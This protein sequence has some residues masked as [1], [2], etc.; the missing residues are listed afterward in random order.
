M[1]RT[2]ARQVSTRS[3]APKVPGEDGWRAIAEDPDQIFVDYEGVL[4]WLARWQHPK[5]L[6]FKDKV[7]KMEGVTLNGSAI[8]RWLLS[9]LDRDTFDRLA[10]EVQAQPT[11]EVIENSV[12]R[13]PEPISA[14][15][16]PA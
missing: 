10:R 1:I 8:D 2:V 16:R 11:D 3:G 15:R 9:E 6:A 12:R 14:N 7:S 5:L 4:P 13:I